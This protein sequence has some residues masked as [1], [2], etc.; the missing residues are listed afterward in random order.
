LFKKHL[1]YPEHKPIGV[2]RMITLASA[3]NEYLLY[4][5]VEKGASHSTLEAYQRD[6]HRFIAAMDETAPTDSLEYQGIVAYL[7]QL[8]ELGYAP[9]SLKRNVAAIKAFCKFMVQDGLATNN[10]AGILKMPKV[11]AHLPPTL[12]IEQI[13]ELLDQEFELTPLGARNKAILELLYGCGLRVSELVNLDRA[14]CNLGEGLIRVFGKGSKERIV[15]IGGTAM[16]AL[17]KYLR[18]ARGLLHTKKATAPPEDSAVFL[19]VRGQRLSRQGVYDIVV[20]YGMRVDL[21]NLHPHSLRHTYATHL[22]DGGGDLRSIQQLLGHASISTTQIYTHVGRRHLRE[23][24]LTCH[25]RA[26][27]R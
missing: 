11:P 18:E 15:P 20:E 5:R 3:L 19:N 8:V 9:S 1:F 10:A 16:K 2:Y 12:S 26:R 7:A 24:Y 14:E 22:L 21:Q 25:P 23:E 4:L 13:N 6:L 17:G 27:M